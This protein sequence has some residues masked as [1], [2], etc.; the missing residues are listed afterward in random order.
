MAELYPSLVA[1]SKLFTYVVAG[2]DHVAVYLVMVEIVVDIDDLRHSYQHKPLSEGQQ[3]F[4]VL[5]ACGQVAPG[6][7]RCHCSMR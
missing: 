6:I 2:G 1:Q 3:V 5:I 7:A 4:R